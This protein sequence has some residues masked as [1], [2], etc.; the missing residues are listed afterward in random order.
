M[1]S[2][3]LL[4]SVALAGDPAVYSST[5][6]GAAS[7]PFH[8]Y[9]IPDIA[10]TVVT[11]GATA[12]LGVLGPRDPSGEAVLTGIDAVDTPRWSD[13]AEAASNVLAD[14]RSHYGLNVPVLGLLGIGV[15]SGLRDGS[16]GAG[17]VRSLL[18]VEALSTN[19]AVTEVLK[20][21]VSRPR[22]YTSAAF[23]AAL[24]DV[25]AGAEVQR[26]LSAAGHYD[27]YKSFPSGHTSSAGVIGFAVATIAWEDAASRGAKP[28][29][30]GV[31]Y[32]TAALYTAAT[33]TLR[34]VAG[35]HNPTDVIAGGLLGA[36]VGTGVI[37]LHTLGPRG[38][39]PAV[40]TT[41]NGLSISGSW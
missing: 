2:S 11:G 25:Y 24:P 34:V 14:P 1:I 18:V 21:L 36:G 28:W 6:R 29:V 15:A 20:D 33:G 23:Q 27:A 9:W 7:G 41:G 13:A 5:W 16:A 8:Y 12:A 39:G 30:A 4:A 40:G 10:L 17:A 32:G 3:L 19:L 26:D 35:K 31:A 37:W 38:G 22:P